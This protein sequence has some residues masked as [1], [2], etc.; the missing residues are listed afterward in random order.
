MVDLLFSSLALIYFVYLLLKIRTV[1]HFL[2]H[3]IPFNF[4]IDLVQY[5]SFWEIMP[6]VRAVYFYYFFALFFF[7]RRT[8]FYDLVLIILLGYS[9]VL[10]FFSS[11]PGLSVRFGLRVFVALILF[12]IAYRA[13]VNRDFL[14]KIVSK[15]PAYLVCFIVYTLLSNVLGFGMVTYDDSS[16]ITGFLFG[17]DLL[18]ISFFIIFVVH[19]RKEISVNKYLIYGSVIISFLILL[20]TLRRTTVFVVIFGVFFLNLSPKNFIKT[21]IP[22][23][24]ILVFSSILIFQSELF[25]QRFQARSEKVSIDSLEEELRYLETYIV[26]EEIFSFEDL[27]KSIFGE[28]LFNSAGYYG[29]GVFGRRIIHIDYWQWLNGSGILGLSIYLL[30]LFVIFIFYTKVKLP[31]KDKRLFLFLYVVQYIISF[32]GQ[33]YIISFRALIFMFMGLLLASNRKKKQSQIDSN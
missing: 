26:L 4:F 33:M 16:F 21:A 7:K 12:S 15:F 13:N 19:Y 20:F 23:S 25:Q 2:Y 32:S 24:L 14:I 27:S 28:Q 11:D 9:T 31:P 18:I 1:N 10:F 22:L 3:V 29:N 30:L 5:W 17:S 8:N 6:V